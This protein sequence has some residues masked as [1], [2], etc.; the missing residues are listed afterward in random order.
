MNC[1]PGSKGIWARL[2]SDAVRQQQAPLL[3]AAEEAERDRALAACEPWSVRVG[4][5]TLRVEYEDPIEPRE[6]ESRGDEQ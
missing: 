3:S 6:D 4:E 2:L 5:W 1:L